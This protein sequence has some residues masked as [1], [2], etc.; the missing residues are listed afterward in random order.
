MSECLK[1]PDVT[2][3]TPEGKARKA[4]FSDVGDL[5]KTNDK[6]MFALISIKFP[7]QYDEVQ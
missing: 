1:H 6:L 4:I 5:Q 2:P 7:T 3:F